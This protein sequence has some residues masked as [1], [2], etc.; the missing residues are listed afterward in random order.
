MARLKYEDDKYKKLAN[1]KNKNSKTWWTLLKSIHSN[2]DSSL[3]VPPLE[4]N[5]KIIVDDKEKAEAFNKKNLEAS[6]INEADAELPLNHNITE[7][8]NSLNS[9][10]IK[11]KDVLDQMQILNTSKAY[12]PDGISPIFIKDGGTKTQSAANTASRSKGRN[13]N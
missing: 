13:R 6:Q 9:I 1:D 8:I 3:S 2:S 4:T 7:N 5:N 12:G 10:D 11:R